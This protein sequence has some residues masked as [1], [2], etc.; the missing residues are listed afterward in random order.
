MS[1]KISQGLINNI[2]FKVEKEDT[3][4]IWKPDNVEIYDFKPVCNYVV[5]YLVD[6]GFMT[7]RKC[8]VLIV[9]KSS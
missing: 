6:E 5:K 1:W 9:K 7:T 2:Q 8:K 4:K 3:V